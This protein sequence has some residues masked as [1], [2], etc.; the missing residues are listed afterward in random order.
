MI[1]EFENPEN[2]K[3]AEIVIGIPS[4]NEADSITFPVQQTDLGLKQF[5]PNVPS[6]I[7]NVDNHSPDGTKDV[8]LKTKTNAPKIYASTP[9]G[10][11]GK[12]RN[13]KNLFGIAVELNAKKIILLDADLKSITPR[14][15]Y[16]LIEPLIDGYDLVAPI[17]IRHKYDGTITNNIAYPLLRTLYGIRVRQPIAGEFGISGKLARSYLMEKTWNEDIYNFGIDI[18]MTIN[19]ICR[20]FKV[21]QT[22]LD[23]SKSHRPKEPTSDLGP[24]FSQVVG[25]I[26]RLMNGSENIWSNISG[27]KPNVIYGFGLGMSEDYPEIELDAENLYRSYLSGLDK[28][29]KLWR[30]I[31][32]TENWAIVSNLKN[33]TVKDFKFRTAT[34]ARTLFDFA[35]AYRN[36]GI[37]QEHLLNALIPFYHSRILDFYN[38]SKEMDTLASEL[39][40][41]NANRN[42]EAEKDYLVKRWFELLKEP[43]KSRGRNHG[44]GSSQLKNKQQILNLL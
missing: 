1:Y 3:S 25:T 39:Y 17:Y 14:W 23:G 15:V 20:N 26:F 35:V 4:Y 8:F 37:D 22:F 38:K 9:E 44:F 40:L 32:S 6:V 27:S 18:W 21:C 41:E 7:V 36:N 42:F 16:Y 12:G 24:M 10:M 13:I 43:V 33:Y 19:A 11:M 28:Y 2:V 29:G 30:Q 31:L 34:W 5:F